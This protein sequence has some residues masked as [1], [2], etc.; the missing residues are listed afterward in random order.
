MSKEPTTYQRRSTATRNRRQAQYDKQREQKA[1]MRAYSDA[2]TAWRLG[3]KV[4]ESPQMKDY[5]KW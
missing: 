2:M 4:G 3:G 5:W 1:A